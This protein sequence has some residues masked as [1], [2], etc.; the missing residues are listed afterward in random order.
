MVDR[1][2]VIL[3]S[4]GHKG[5]E[6]EFGRCAHRFGI[7]EVTFSFP[8]HKMEWS[9]ELRM[10]TPAEL[11][12]GDVSMEIVSRHMGRSYTQLEMVR[13]VIQ[14]MFHIVVNSWQVFAVGWVQPD[15]TVQGGTGWG[16]ELAKLF[17]RPVSVFDQAQGQWFSWRGGRWLP[18]T[19]LVG[20]RPFAATG[21][22]HLT[23]AGRAAI[24][25]LFERSFGPPP[26]LPTRA[27]AAAK[28]SARRARKPAKP[29]ARPAPK[30]PKGVRA[31]AARA[32]KPAGRRPPKRPKAKARKR[33]R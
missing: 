14:S 13:R 22:R 8:G 6:A 32:K 20:G 16:V 25:S 21:T 31:K 27:P 17:N 23:D 10:L 11:A 28:A 15:G 19:P 29:K 4:G 33:R 1:N 3:V 9:G 5:T 12:K 30:R 7:H 2:K 26:E 24:R 18:D